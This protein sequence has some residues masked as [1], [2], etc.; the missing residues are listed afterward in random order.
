M[1][2][3]NPGGRDRV[4]CVA[5]NIEVLREV[6]DEI[7]EAFG[8]LLP[9][10][11]GL[12][13]AG[14][15]GPDPGGHRLVQHRAGGPRAGR[16]GAP[17]EIIGTLTLAHLPDPDRHAG[18]DRGRGRGRGRPGAGPGG[19]DVR[20]LRI[21]RSGA[22]T[23]DLTSRPSRER[24]GGC[25]SGSDSR[26]AIPGCTG[27]RSRPGR[28]RHRPGPSG[29]AHLLDADARVEQGVAEVDDEVGHDDEHGGGQHEADDQGQVALVDRPTSLADAT[30]PNTDSMTTT[31]PSR[32]P[33]SMPSWEPRGDPDRIPCRNMTR[34]SGSPFARAVRM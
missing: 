11:P 10:C 33:T 22:R 4:R 14:P 15:R 3:R 29:R 17:G 31:P 8:R 18:L 19:A 13:D 20:G 30:D 12:R 7:V 6:T 32:V 27:S 9:S 24:P 25:T 23:V 5:V 26:S 21:A 34:R 28:R 16:G 2:P 1:P